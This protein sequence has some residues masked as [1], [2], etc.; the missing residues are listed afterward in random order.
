VQCPEG[1]L[2]F[3][4]DDGGRSS[5]HPSHAHESAWQAH[6]RGAQLTPKDFVDVDHV[7]SG[8]IV[9]ARADGLSFASPTMSFSRYVENQ[10]IDADSYW[11]LQI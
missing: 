3:R 9:I 7:G 2:R 1:A 10:P 11:K 8:R 5:D 6:G 4:Y